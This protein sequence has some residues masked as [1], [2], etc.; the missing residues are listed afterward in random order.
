MSSV[1][2]IP[3]IVFVEQ[4]GLTLGQVI[5]FFLLLQRGVEFPIRNILKQWAYRLTKFDWLSITAS[6]NG[7]CAILRL[8]DSFWT[9]GRWSLPQQIS[10]L[11]ENCK[12]T[13]DHLPLHCW[14]RVIFKR[15]ERHRTFFACS[16]WHHILCTLP[17]LHCWVVTVP[18]LG[19]GSLRSSCWYEGICAHRWIHS[20]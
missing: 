20:W 5:M 2:F 18:R 6:F 8:G 11:L 17:I 14:S 7:S 16:N 4:T 3:W 12:L 10:V 19:Q 1:D 13:A 9:L 15:H